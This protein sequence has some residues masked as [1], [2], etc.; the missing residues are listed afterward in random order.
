MIRA[1]RW[2][3]AVSV[4]GLSDE[5]K[6]RREQNRLND[7]SMQLIALADDPGQVKAVCV[8]D[9]SELEHTHDD[10]HP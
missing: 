6:K 10:A 1:V 7:R 8:C 3:V 2:C 5:I 9:E 4:F